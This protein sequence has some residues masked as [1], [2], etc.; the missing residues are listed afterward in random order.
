MTHDTGNNS[1]Q[2][3]TMPEYLTY[4]TLS[5]LSY[6]RVLGIL[7]HWID[8]SHSRVGSTTC[9]TNGVEMLPLPIR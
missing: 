5:M 4:I 1:E 7:A 6:L 3:Q 9:P 2:T 8:E